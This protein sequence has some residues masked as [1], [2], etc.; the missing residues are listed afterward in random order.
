MKTK[1]IQYKSAGRFSAAAMAVLL[2]AGSPA[3]FAEDT[4]NLALQDCS[5]KID[6]AV[7]TQDETKI[8]AEIAGKFTTLAGSDAN[9]TALVTGLHAG[10]SITLTSTVDGKDV[11]TTITP[12]TSQQGFGS[13][14]ITLAL[15]QAEL[16]KMGITN[17]TAA[18]LEA[19]LNGGSI[20]T[21]TGAV[22]VSGIL[23]LRASGQGW[24]QIAQTLDVKLGRVL[25]ETR[26]AG[27]R[28]EHHMLSDMAKHDRPA[29]ADRAVD[30]VERISTRPERPLDRVERVSVVDRPVRID[31][32]MR[33]ERARH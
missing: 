28:F 14:Y 12:A 24:G 8:T 2:L 32:P 26:A 11:T 27:E 4:D 30:K 15:A 18:Q 13:V 7:K 9:A 1:N 22:S 29:K 16:T 6:A 20:T 17:P 25:H 3:A 33:P 31:L 5:T 21:A 23:A 10:T 19:I